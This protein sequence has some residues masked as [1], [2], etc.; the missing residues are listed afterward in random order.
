MRKIFPLV[1]ILLLFLSCKQNTENK[2]IKNIQVDNTDK[3][4]FTDLF[5]EHKLI[6][7][8][9]KDSAWF[10]SSIRRIEKYP[11]K[12]FILN[13]LQTRRNILCF[14]VNG[15]FLFNIDKTG[16]GPGE[17]TYLGDFLIDNNLNVL[18]LNVV[19]NQ[20]GRDEY[21]YFSLDGEYLYSKKATG[22]SGTIRLMKE[23]NDSLYVAYADCE[24]KEDCDDIV[25]LD[26]QDLALKKSASYTSSI[27][28]FYALGLSICGTSDAFFFYGGNDTIYDISTELGRKIPVYFVDFGK[29]QQRF[30]QNLMEKEHEEALELHIKAFANKEIRTVNKFLSNEKYFVVNYSENK[31]A[32]IKRNL[33]YNTVFYD[34]ATKKSYNTSNMNFDIFNSVKNDKMSITGCADGYF[35]AVLLAPFSEEEIK[36][37]VKSKFL[38]EE[39]KQAF[40]N[41]NDDSNSV[42]LMF[43]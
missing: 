18:V 29:K 35:Y 11:G 39:N 36:E 1:V 7:P 5:S 13:E 24:S 16:N 25:F 6:F 23:F 32:G 31:T 33:I 42:I 19:G 20:Y 10:G 21:M 38:S 3:V 28:A 27:N 30:K 43:K 14:D 26:R 40:L 12:I 34:R 41:M 2:A 37:I 22:L 8:E 17:Y 9:S 15:R 4:N